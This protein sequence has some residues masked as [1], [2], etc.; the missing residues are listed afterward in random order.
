MKKS[1]DF[2]KKVMPLLMVFAVIVIPLL[3]S[4]LYLGSVWNPYSLLSDL[5]V[6][7][8]NEDAGAVASGKEYRLGEQLCNKLKEDATLKFAFVSKDEALKGT[9][10][11]DYYAA[12]LIPADFSECI[13]SAAT[14]NPRQAN[15][16]YMVNE[17][18]NFLA[19]QILSK[20]VSEIKASLQAQVDSEIVNSLTGGVGTAA[21]GASALNDGAKSLDEGIGTLRAGVSE[22]NKSAAKLTELQNGTAEL[23]K[24]AGQ[25][26]D[27]VRTYTLGVAQ[28]IN[29][30]SQLS[31]ELESVVRGN[32]LLLLDP[33]FSALITRLSSS[34]NAQA[35]EQL[36]QGTRDLNVA[37]KKL[38]A[39]STALADGAKS[40]PQLLDGIDQ[41]QS[42][43]NALK[44]GSAELYSGT[45]T[46]SGALAAADNT[47]SED[48]FSPLAEFAAQ[49][50]TVTPDAINP[51]A[52][53]GTGFAPYF[54]SLSLWMGALVM[55]LG[56]FLE[57]EGRFKVL[58]RKTKSNTLRTLG[59]LGIGLVEST[60]LGIVMLIQGLVVEH[61]LMYFAFCWLFSLLCV[62][63]MQFLIVQFK[64]VGKFL[65]IVLL[66]LQLTSSGGMF[67]MELVPKLFNKLYYFMPMAYSVSLLKEAISGDMSSP[68][69]LRNVMVLL[70]ALVVFLVLNALMSARGG[71]KTK[72][73]E[74]DKPADQELIEEFKPAQTKAEA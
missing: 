31:T 41:L 5:P 45:Q 48:G 15:L 1:F 4:S 20:A 37:A 56:I 17:K 34:D 26:S 12:I 44:S 67:P 55:F 62:A 33:N 21:E 32:P 59:F 7:I 14:A 3:Y 39:G 6:A 73:I 57:T 50:L 22:M 25:L 70:I 49:P 16:T 27:G 40:I 66:I 29:S 47:T 10:G 74:G 60:L 71:K 72:P 64:D 2:K 58:A 13:A 42:G 38:A 46:L 8:V 36:R 52:N 28:L 65:A 63:I 51:V 23:A 35:L 69:L 30:V 24:G 53:Y 54:M 19:G 43:A 61:L 18:K 68:V 11:S 9:N